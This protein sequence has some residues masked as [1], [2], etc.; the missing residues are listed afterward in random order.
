[1][2]FKKIFLALPVLNEIDSLPKLI[3][4]IRNQTYKNF[5]VFVCVNQ[6]EEWWNNDKKYIC[7]NN[8]KT[9]EYLKNIKDIKINIID[10]SCRG[11]AWDDKH[12]G[13]GFA[14]KTIMDAIIPFAKNY[15]IILSVD[16]DTIFEAN[17]LKSVVENFNIH[18]NATALSVP[19]YHKLTDDEEANRAILH[20]EIYMRYYSINMFRIKSPYCF[21]ALGSAIAVPVWAYKSIGGMT[22]HKSGEDFYFLQKLRKYGKLILWNNLKVYPEAR[23]SDR[24]FFGTGPAM[25]KGKNNDW[26]SYPIYH[27]SLFDEIEKFYKIIPE[28]YKSDI[29]IPFIDF[30]NNSKNLFKPLRD[31]TKNTKSFVKACHNKFD[32][33]RILQFLKSSQKNIKKSDESIL[34]EFLLKF[35]NKK[36]KAYFDDKMQ[37]FS[38]NNSSIKELNAMRNF[39]MSIEEDYQKKD[40]ELI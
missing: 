35:Y 8:Q 17:Y 2:S 4:C 33:L 26:D 38:F 11:K 39:L 32:G 30:F 22:P 20:Y 7:E 13:V 23:F 12:Y 24:V 36:F 31:N 9:I 29:S 19:Y 14:R 28:L 40:Y 3:N 21:T 25:I 37:N 1:M 5:E 16:A 10:K 15:D 6:P 34:I 27:Y 18:K